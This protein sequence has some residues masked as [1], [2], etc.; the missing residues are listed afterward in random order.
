M[1]VPHLVSTREFVELT[2]MDLTQ[3]YLLYVSGK[4]PINKKRH[5]TFIDINDVRAKQYLPDYKP[6][7][8]LFS[9]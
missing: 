2:K 7:K 1:A 4:L 5:D 3:F 9:T 6:V 8:D